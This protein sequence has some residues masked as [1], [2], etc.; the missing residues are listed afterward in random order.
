MNA[1]GIKDGIGN[2]P[3]PTVVSQPSTVESSMSAPIDLSKELLLDSS[4]IQ[5]AGSR[6]MLSSKFNP[7]TKGHGQRPV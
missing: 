7:T 6:I 1:I 2:T 3:H 4:K 5:A